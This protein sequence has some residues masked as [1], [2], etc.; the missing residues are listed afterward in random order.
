M[1]LLFILFFSP[2]PQ[3]F[4]HLNDNGFAIKSESSHQFIRCSTS[5]NFL[6]AQPINNDL[7]VGAQGTANTILYPPILV[8]ILHHK[9]QASACQAFPNYPLFIKWLHREDVHNSNEDPIN[10]QEG[11][12]L[13][14]LLKCHSSRDNSNCVFFMAMSHF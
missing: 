5:W 14:S 8:M 4:L 1:T 10:F 7:F 2:F 6:N 12:R 13:Q 3:H 11:T 9:Y